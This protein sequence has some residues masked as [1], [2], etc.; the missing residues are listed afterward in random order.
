MVDKYTKICIR[1]ILTTIILGAT[2]NKYGLDNIHMLLVA[3]T[4]TVLGLIY[5]ELMV[6]R[7]EEKRRITK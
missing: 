1:T 6:K 2:Y 5:G 3:T 7:I 4:A